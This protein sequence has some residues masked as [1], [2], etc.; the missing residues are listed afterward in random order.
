LNVLQIIHV[1]AYIIHGMF[2]RESLIKEN[3]QLWIRRKQLLG[4]LVNNI[5]P[6]TE[7]IL[8]AIPGFCCG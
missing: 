8:F 4:E 1:V 5:Y 7:V 3:A 2:Y 6:I